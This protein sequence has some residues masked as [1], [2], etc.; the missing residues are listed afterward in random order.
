MWKSAELPIGWIKGEG[1]GGGMWPFWLSA[2][3]LV[4]CIGI[5]VNWARRATWP[6]RSNELFFAPGVLGSVAPVA[7]ALAVTIALF[8]FAGAYLAL[9]AF[10]MFYLKVLGGY[11]FASSLLASLAIPVVTF[12]FFEIALKIILPKGFTEPFFLP[13]FKWFGM[14][15]L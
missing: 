11:R 1:P 10:L 6:S 9:F 7:I 15:G 14:G 12:F 2:I 5:L 13:I 3:M 8:S 4:S